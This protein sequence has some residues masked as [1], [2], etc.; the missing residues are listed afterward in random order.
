MYIHTADDY[1]AK[2]RERTIKVS[3][4]DKIPYNVLNQLLTV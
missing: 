3:K 1:N 2:E 4:T